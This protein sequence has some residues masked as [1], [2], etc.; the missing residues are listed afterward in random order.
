MGSTFNLR[1]FEYVLRFISNKRVV[2][3]CVSLEIMQISVTEIL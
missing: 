2:A 1:A 3:L